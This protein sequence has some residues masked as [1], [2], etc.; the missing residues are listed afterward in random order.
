M[1]LNLDGVEESVTRFKSSNQDNYIAFEIDGTSLNQV[2]SGTDGLNGVV[3]KFDAQ[4]ILFGL[5]KVF[6]VDN[7]GSRRTK[8]VFF[9]FVGTSVSPLKRA[10]VSVQKPE[11]IK[12]VGSYACQFEVNSASDLDMKSIAKELCRSS[13]AHKPAYYD[14]GSAKFETSLLDD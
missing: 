8:F 2:G 7:E 1:S 9:T 3:S 14:F 11:I 6:C 13:G 5:L 10:K 4:K 12:A